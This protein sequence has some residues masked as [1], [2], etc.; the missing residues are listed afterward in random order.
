[1]AHVRRVLLWCEGG[2]LA[3]A[4]AFLAAPGA[5]ASERDS[6]RT[7]YL[8]YVNA[9]ARGDYRA[10]CGLMTERMRRGGIRGVRLMQKSHLPGVPTKPVKTCAEAVA[11]AQ[12]R[13]SNPWKHVR[14]LGETARIT[15]TGSHAA[16]TTEGSTYLRRQQGRWLMDVT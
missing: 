5:Q 10:A 13:V 3:L 2:V 7:A 9:M 8:K 16:R 12:T 6:V 11:V 4:V 14:K 1:M 15:I